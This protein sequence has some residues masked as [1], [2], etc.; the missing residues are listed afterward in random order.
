MPDR[1]PEKRSRRNAGAITLREV[2]ALAGVAPIT[3]SRALNTPDKVSA[4]VRTR[5]LTAVQRTGY[6]PNRLAGGLASARSRLIAAVTPSTVMS[7]FMGTIEALN[8]TLFDA[9][10][11]LLLGQSSYSTSREELLLEAIIGQRPDG[12]FLTGILLPGKARSRLIASKIPVVESWD[13][14]PTPIDMLVGFSHDAV[15]AAVAGF[16]IKKNH[17]R[18]ALI[19]ADDARATR[20]ADAFKAAVVQ[21]QLP[22]VTQ[23]NIKAMR[24][25]EG[26]R[27]AL[28]E[29][30]ERKI[31]FDAVYCS[32]DLLALGVLT[33]A[34]ARGISVPDSLAI[35][36]FGDT[37]YGRDAL[38]ALSSV[39]IH[40]ERIGEL[41]AQ[42]LIER[43]QGRDVPNPIV[44]VGFTIVEREST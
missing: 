9:G 1:L 38:P 22:P 44:D 17:R 16:L 31:K 42:F 3:A 27:R 34:R 43:A 14:T 28:M 30:L 25:V 18:F 20:R 40:S 13:L 32:S 2:A 15:G 26:G 33:E 35:I 4:D 21:A 36:G 39:R 5:V 7:V 24:T 10:Y 37:T 23:I 29:L 6:V 41:S 12:I 11:Q 8:T 19:S